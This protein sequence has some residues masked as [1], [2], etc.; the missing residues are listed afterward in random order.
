LAEVIHI[1]V[2]TQKPKRTLQAN[3]AKLL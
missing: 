1:S 2:T 3:A